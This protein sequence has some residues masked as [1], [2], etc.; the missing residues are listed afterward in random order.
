MA[1]ALTGRQ[2]ISH[3]CKVFLRYVRVFLRVSYTSPFLKEPSPNCATSPFSSTSKPDVNEWGGGGNAP[4]SLFYFASLGGMQGFLTSR[5]FV[6]T[7][8][9]QLLNVS[10]SSLSSWDTIHED[11]HWMVC[12]TNAAVLYVALFVWFW[13]LVTGQV[14]CFWPLGPLREIFYSARSPALG[15]QRPYPSCSSLYHHRV[16]TQ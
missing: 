6:D 9:K 10:Y 11:G 12:G 8:G 2:T 15:R 1:L 4:F 3:P 14:G 5:W 16:G 7:V 13:L